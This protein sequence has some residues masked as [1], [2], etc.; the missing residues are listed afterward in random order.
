MGD[1]LEI[2]AELPG[3][4]EKDVEVTVTG[5]ILTIKGQKMVEHEEEGDNGTHTE[6]HT[7]SFSRSVRL[8]FEAHDD[9]IDATLDNGV[10]TIRVHR[11]AEE[12]KAGR[13]I[14]VK[15]R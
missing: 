14:Q 1:K 15:A 10:L 4:D 7:E 13:R 11:L 12:Q 9:K 8:P 5:D 2:T 6:R 3:V